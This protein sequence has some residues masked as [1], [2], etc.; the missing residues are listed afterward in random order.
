MSLNDLIAIP[1]GMIGAFFWLGIIWAVFRHRSDSDVIAFKAM[2]F[3]M[4]LAGILA[5]MFPRYAISGP[6]GAMTTFGYLLV[7]AWF[8]KSR[9]L[10]LTKVEGAN[11]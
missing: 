5:G 1:N 4:V 3:L 7:M 6:K 10:S 9:R 11:A 2:A 8:W